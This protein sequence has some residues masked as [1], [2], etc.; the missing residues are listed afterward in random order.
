MFIF[1]FLTFTWF[2]TDEPK[3]KGELFDLKIQGRRCFSE[4]GLSWCDLLVYRGEQRPVLKGNNKIIDFQ[5]I[6][7]KIVGNKRR[8]LGCYCVIEP[9]FV[10]DLLEWGK[11]CF[12]W[13]WS[14]YCIMAGL[15]KGILQG[16]CSIQVINSMW[17]FS[18]LLIPSLSYSKL[19]FHDL[20]MSVILRC[21]RILSNLHIRLM[22]H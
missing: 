16:R 7:W 1:F 8:P 15:A 22:R 20:M 19:I 11:S 3:V 12:I 4:K 13:C 2:L 14:L 10:L 17:I 6:S 18:F 21:C 9:K 5:L